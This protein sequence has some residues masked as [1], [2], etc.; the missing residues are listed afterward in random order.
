ML[1][2]LNVSISQIDKI[3]HALG[4][5]SSLIKK[6]KY[7]PYRNHYAMSP[8]GD[9]FKELQDLCLKGYMYTVPPKDEG[10]WYFYVSKQGFELLENLTGV[11]LWMSSD[12]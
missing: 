3:K 12:L 4:F 5:D 8:S 2:N 10:M 1:N 9:V 11:E 7:K 6:G